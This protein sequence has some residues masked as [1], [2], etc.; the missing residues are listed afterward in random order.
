MIVNAGRLQNQR[1]GA[2]VKVIFWILILSFAGY[3]GYKL[4]PPYFNYK[5]MKYEVRSEA[6]NAHV[7]TDEEIRDRLLD[8]AK[9]WSVPMASLDITIHRRT[10]FIDI[11]L[12]YSVTVTFFQRYKRKLDYDISVR[13]P[14]K[15]GA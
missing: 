12:G 2:G 7:Y 5:M 1:G 14:L 6:E 15:Q 13:E 11:S 8:K 9:N 10:R 3:S 4:I